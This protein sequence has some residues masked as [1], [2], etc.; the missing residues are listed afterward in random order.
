MRVT[1]LGDH[2][3]DGVLLGSEAGDHGLGGHRG[4][5]SRQFLRPDE[6]RLNYIKPTVKRIGSNKL[7][8]S[9]LGLEILQRSGTQARLLHF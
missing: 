5:L 4:V 2:G 8:G 9:K 1:G 6:L 7:L 3:I